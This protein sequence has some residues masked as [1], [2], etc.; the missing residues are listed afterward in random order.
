VVSP[1]PGRSLAKKRGAHRLWLVTTNDNT[2]ALRFYQRVAFD[3][4]ALHGDTVLAAR[5][6]K[7]AMSW[8]FTG[9]VTLGRK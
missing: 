1:P 3:L 2:A 9:S 7:P 6:L 5:V 4:A 8:N